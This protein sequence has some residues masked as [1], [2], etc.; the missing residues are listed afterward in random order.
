MNTIRKQQLS[1]REVEGA[2]RTLE[3]VIADMM[4]AERE[5]ERLEKHRDILSEAFARLAAMNDAGIPADVRL[6][7]DDTIARIAT[8]I[9][10]SYRPGT[11]EEESE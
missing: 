2:K 9:G 6:L 7:V 10:P 3:N 4:R 5:I 11:N 1:R 8:Q